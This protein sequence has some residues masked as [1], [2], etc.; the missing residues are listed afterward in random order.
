MIQ[1]ITG[2]DNKTLKLIKS[3]RKKSNR[4]EQKKFVAEGKRIVREAFEFVPQSIHSVVVS[5][6]FFEKEVEFVKRAEVVCDKVMVVSEQ[7]F[8][9]ISDTDT[10][11]GVLAVV[12][13]PQEEFFAD[14]NAKDIV[15]LDEVSEPGNLGTV[16]RTA[17]AF[18]FDGIYLMKGC[19]DIFSPKTVRATMGS[20]FR[21]K[22]RSNCTGED[23]KLLKAEGFSIVSTTPSGEDLLESFKAPKKTAV[24][25]GNEAHGICGDILENSD[26][27]VKISMD[28]LAESL[29][30][31][32]AA[33]IA[34]HWIKN[35]KE[36]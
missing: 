28:G 1:R 14:E 4:S 26:F 3:L 11:Q 7:I 30:A 34:M 31:A 9:D 25:I 13:M 21:M 8:T 20:V 24:V 29:N 17:E 36:E 19:A 2:K 23:I 10:P 22:F 27:R 35:C 32:V 12:R 33:G 15:I 16:I 18:G 6:V 5:E